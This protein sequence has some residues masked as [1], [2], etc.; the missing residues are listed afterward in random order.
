MNEVLDTAAKSLDNQ[1]R[2]RSL[3]I[4]QINQ[5]L[6]QAYGVPEGIQKQADAEDK[7]LIIYRTRR[8]GGKTSSR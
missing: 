7:R 8:F 3:T 5:E 1:H 2:I 6:L 4:K